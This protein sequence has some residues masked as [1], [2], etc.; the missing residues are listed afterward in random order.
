MKRTLKTVAGAGHGKGEKRCGA[1]TR[2]SVIPR[3]AREEN[4]RSAREDLLTRGY[5][6]R[7]RPVSPASLPSRFA[8]PRFR[9]R[10]LGWSW[11]VLIGVT[12]SWLAS[13]GSAW[14]QSNYATPYAF[15]TLA[16]VPGV[17]GSADGAS[18]RF[19]VPAGLAIDREGNV[20]VCDYSNHTIRRV[21]P[22]G[23]VTTFAGAAGVAG[24]TNGPRLSARFSGPAGL[25]FD[26]AGNLYVAEY[27]G[28]LIRKIATD[29]TV[30]TIAGAA[31]A[32]ATDGPG[33]TARF[34]DPEGVVADRAGN[35]F[36]ADTGNNAIRKIT[37]AGVVSTFAGLAGASGSG[38]VDGPGTSARFRFPISIAI[39]AADNLYVT[40]HDNHLV[41]KITPAGIVSTLAGGVTQ[42]GSTDGTG[43]AA[44]FNNPNGITVDAAGNVFVVERTNHLVRR[45]TPAGVVTTLGGLAG[46]NGSAN[47][48]GSVARFDS[49]VGI[50]VADNGALT[51]SDTVNHTLRLGVLAGNAAKF[52]SITVPA[53]VPAGAAVVEARALAEQPGGGVI[54]GVSG[55]YAVR[56]NAT[57]RASQAL[58][59]PDY[60]NPQPYNLSY[61][62]RLLANGQPDPAFTSAPGG[63]GT[64]NTVAVQTDGKIVVGGTFTTFN[65]VLFR[66]LA[67]LNPDG[68]ADATFVLGSGVD[69]QVNALAVQA[70]GKILVGG[71]FQNF[72]GQ[73]RPYLLRLNVNGSLD[74]TFAPALNGTVNSLAVQADGRIVIGGA[75]TTVGGTA[76]NRVARLL[77]S[78]AIDPGFDPGAGGND[79]VV[80]LALQADGKIV[81]GGDFTSFAG[82]N[83]TRIVRLLAAGTI[84]PAFSTAAANATVLSVAVQTD[85][86]LMIG[87]A[88]TAMNGIARARLARLNADGTLDASF[89]P[90]AGANKDVRALLPRSDGTLYLGGLFDQYQGAATNEVV[91]VAGVAMPTTIVRAPV[92]FTVNAGGTAL[93]VAEATGSGVLTY[94]WFKD[95]TAIPG[96]T[97]STLTLA[98]ASAANQGSYTLQVN[99]STGNVTTSTGAALT[100]TAGSASQIINLSVLTSIEANETFTVGFALGGAG[101]SGAKSL[102]VRAGGPSL[103]AYGVSNPLSDPKLQFFAGSAP[104]GENDNWGGGMPLSTLMAQV[105]AY[106]YTNPASKDSAFAPTQ[107]AA[108]NSVIVSSAAGA[109]AVIAEV[110]D[111]TPGAE[112]TAATPRLL[113]VSVL[114]T[115]PAGSVLTA[116]FVIR[117]NTTKTVLL[118]VVGPTLSNFGVGNPMAD[119][120]L[121]VY[122][123]DGSV[124][125]TND[126]W[127]GTA[128]LKSAFTSV[129]AFSL[130]GTTKDAAL[131]L[132]LSPGSYSAE[133]TSA[134]ATTGAAIVE[135]YEVP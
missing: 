131:L 104:A 60:T 134:N 30:S 5:L 32:G 17:S 110:Y 85:G 68:K 3:T 12:A 46:V 52:P 75:F 135:V 29:G 64:V 31:T 58:L 79:E 22:A 42:A 16:G 14:A 21:T 43:T 124:L 99:S 19:F 82:L 71:A 122:R 13:A 84:D 9:L 91:A 40:D 98:N 38:F 45:I 7:R 103:S 18:A 115:I 33:A 11:S 28:N 92:A 53:L 1:A 80:T 108:A 25:G 69:A 130:E 94:Q 49:A 126:N 73:S 55:S 59:A 76:R 56:P 125:A 88:F 106:A 6:Q 129:G 36:I 128:A 72:A 34:F 67:R 86:T 114:K 51:V 112:N 2:A 74:A 20:Y 89:D 26:A 132:N 47:G 101:T 35:L 118:R 107:T 39:D 116:G 15:T 90:G 96:A 24:A 81:A 123:G 77:A 117:G 37:P 111:A 27:T 63:D 109:G 10:F 127:N 4:R 50:V 93:F 78:G 57:G 66:N 48:T 133:A 65:G 105:G 23:V 97:E 102:L 100:V 61:V 83:R 44:R 62:V 119:P 54:V 87:G 8:L 41:R 120:K 121:T 113:N 70:D 95:G